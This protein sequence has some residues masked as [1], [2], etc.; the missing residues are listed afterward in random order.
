[1][2]T[3]V[4]R[5]Y[6]G[7]RT[8]SLDETCVTS[9]ML[10]PDVTAK[11]MKKS[12]HVKKYACSGRKNVQLCGRLA[13]EL[14]YDIKRWVTTRQL[15]T[16]YFFTQ[17]VRGYGIILSPT[18][19]PLCHARCPGIEETAKGALSTFPIRKRHN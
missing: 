9:G 2:R 15:S 16:K 13:H 6:C 19:M 14:M 3:K 5:L 17:K 1:M 10:L 7:F 4:L 18:I 8:I 12:Y 11:S